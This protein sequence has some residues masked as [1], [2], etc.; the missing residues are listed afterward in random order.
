M[1]ATNTYKHRIQAAL[2]RSLLYAWK[3]I[4]KKWWSRLP[5]LSLYII[6]ECCYFSLW[7]AMLTFSLECV[8][9]H[10]CVCVCWHLCNCVSIY[11]CMGHVCISY[12]SLFFLH[13]FVASLVLFFVLLFWFKLQLDFSVLPIPKRIIL[14]KQ[15]EMCMH[16]C[17][18]FNKYYEHRIVQI[19]PFLHFFFYVTHF[20]WSFLQHGFYRCTFF[21]SSF[22]FGPWWIGNLGSLHMSFS[23]CLIEL[24]ERKKKLVHLKRNA[25]K[26]FTVTKLCLSMIN[27]H[28]RLVA[29]CFVSV[30]ICKWNDHL[31]VVVVF[32]TC[33]DC[34]CTKERKK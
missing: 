4:E 20:F 5:P 7:C 22:S 14:I 18:S 16:N 9:V 34:Y 13:F 12:V 30:Y 32:F 25:S 10:L 3:T 6:S 27:D 23:F 19:F 31:F 17:A 24:Y 21:C 11:V 33:S 28:I 2:S 15:T 1:F 8:Y 29:K 26:P